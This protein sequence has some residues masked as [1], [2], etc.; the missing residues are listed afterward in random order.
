MSENKFYCYS[1]GAR[2][3]NYGFFINNGLICNECLQRAFRIELKDIV[4]FDLVKL[5]GGQEG[6]N[7]D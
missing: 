3:Y 4:D 7:H 6:T 2:I 5:L 1:C